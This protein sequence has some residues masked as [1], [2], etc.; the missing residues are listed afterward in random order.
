MPVSR[1]RLPEA[2]DVAGEA[3]GAHPAGVPGFVF[4]AGQAALVE[5]ARDLAVGVAAE[6]LVDLLDHWL[7]GFALLPGVQR[8]RQVRGVVL[9]AGQADGGGDGIVAAGCPAAGRPWGD[10]N[11]IHGPLNRRALSPQAS[12][13]GSRAL[14]SR[15]PPA[16]PPAAGLRPVLDPARPLARTRAPARRN[17]QPRGHFRT[18]S[19]LSWAII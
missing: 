8:D 16:P 15:T 19:N 5:D 14:A 2:G 9:A 13:I 7:G 6:Q 11:R 1:S 17:G 12:I 4:S 18:L 10:D 3:V